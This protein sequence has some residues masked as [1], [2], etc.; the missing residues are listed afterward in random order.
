MPHGVVSEVVPAPRVEVFD[1]VQDYGRRLEWDTLLRAAYLEDGRTTAA[2]GATAV[3]AGRWSLGGITMRTV[4]VSFDRPRVAA[5]KM[6]NSPPFFGARAASIAH[7]AVSAGESR[8]THTWQFTPKPRLLG[9]LLAPFMT[10]VFRV[11]TRRRL[12]A[13]K[14]YLAK[15]KGASAPATLRG[16]PEPPPASSPGTGSPPAAP[17]PPPSATPGSR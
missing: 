17:S 12:R 1:V 2:R 16:R 13:L 10:L 4:Y 14:A 8:V 7:E 3:C 9:W 15:R 5:V 11:E 6:I